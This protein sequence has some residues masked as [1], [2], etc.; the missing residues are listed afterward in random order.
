MVVVDI[1]VFQNVCARI[2][3]NKITYRLTCWNRFWCWFCW[4]Y[5][6]W[7]WFVEEAVGSV[8]GVKCSDPF[9]C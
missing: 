1:C 6:S 9:W 5:K 8:G 2:N 3:K 7:L 4:W